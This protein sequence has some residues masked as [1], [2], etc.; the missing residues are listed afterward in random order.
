MIRFWIFSGINEL[1]FIFT[2]K[3]KLSDE[4]IFCKTF[5]EIPSSDSKNSTTLLSF[6]KILDENNSIIDKIAKFLIFILIKLPLK[7]I[8]YYT[9][10][11]H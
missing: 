8:Y 11:T 3:Q 7:Y 10:N 5:G 2:E 9:L 6:A 1:L 4:D